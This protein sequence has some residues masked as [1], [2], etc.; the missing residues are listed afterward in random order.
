[1]KPI[2]SSSKDNTSHLFNRYVWL[3]D[4]IYRAGKI[5]FE[6]I[7]IKWQQSQLNENAEDLPLKT[8]HNHKTAIQSMFDL[9]IE[10]NRRA[11]Y[12]YY[13]E[14]AEDMERGGVRSWLLNTFA[15]NNL[16]NESHKL[17][18]RILFEHIPSGQ[19]YLLPIIEA[20]NNSVAIEITYQNYWQDTP[21]SFEVAPYCVKVFRQRWYL[22]AYNSY[23]K[24]LRTY[25]LD[26]I[27]NVAMK[28]NKFTI[29]ADFDAKEYFS[30]TFG[31][32]NY[33]KPQSV[34]IKVFNHNNKHKY[35]LD[36]PLH[37]S[38]TLIEQTEDYSIFEYYLQ[39]TYDFRQELLTHGTE[40]EV[41]SPP[42]LREEMSSITEEQCKMYNPKET[43]VLL[44]NFVSK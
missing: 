16:I 1:M 13:I 39:P 33:G 31:I 24:D 3:V 37:H 14:N 42:C 23:F 36:L 28:D 20:M 17:K 22:I 9:N 7:N 38:Q 19:K 2:R 29:P 40:V 21:N 30:N 6:E 15:I 10:C 35:F 11:G 44:K 25:S 4:T 18:H 34:R 43:E 26:R 27:Q 32:I 12:Y 8:F 5:T 41:L